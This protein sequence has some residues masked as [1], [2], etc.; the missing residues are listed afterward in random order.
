[1]SLW[2]GSELSPICV[3]PLAVPPGPTLRRDMQRN[4][5]PSVIEHLHASNKH[6][7][8]PRSKARK[9]RI[10]ARHACTAVRGSRICP[11]CV[12]RTI[13]LKVGRPGSQIRSH[14]DRRETEHSERPDATRARLNVSPKVRPPFWECIREA[15]TDGHVVRCG[16][17][18]CPDGLG[19][20]PPALRP[21]RSL[22][23]RRNLRDP[24]LNGLRCLPI[25]V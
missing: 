20:E 15:G 16:Q 23:R 6:A 24:P 17:R 5:Q 9:Q 21:A 11:P 18:G 19:S 25:N 8:F 4:T 10:R 12:I 14:G 7:P 1:M 3:I 2:C 13:H 22:A